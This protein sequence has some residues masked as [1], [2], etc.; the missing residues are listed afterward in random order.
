MRDAFVCIVGF[1]TV[2]ACQFFKTVFTTN[3]NGT[4]LKIKE[5][6]LL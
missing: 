6:L 3:R 2:H 4:N 1:F 5:L